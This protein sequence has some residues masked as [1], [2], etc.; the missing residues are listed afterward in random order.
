MQRITCPERD[1][2]RATADATEPTAPPTAEE[3]FSVE[4]PSGGVLG[5]RQE[6]QGYVAEPKAQV[7]AS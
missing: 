6:S 1:D 7:R 3:A 2:W 5:G 4:T